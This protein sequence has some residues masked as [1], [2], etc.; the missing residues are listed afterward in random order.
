VRALVFYFL[1]RLPPVRRSPPLTEQYL[2][3][4]SPPPF[5]LPAPT[6]LPAPARPFAASN[7]CAGQ[8]PGWNHLFL[9]FLR[10]CRFHAGRGGR[11]FSR[12]VPS[13]AKKEEVDCRS[14]SF[15]GLLLPFVT[16]FPFPRRPTGVPPSTALLSLLVGGQLMYQLRGSGFTRQPEDE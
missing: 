10:F 1:R 11:A 12:V 3:F 2:R 14:L 13:S 8:A 16:I 15:S 9:F 6:P 4:F 7:L 5:P